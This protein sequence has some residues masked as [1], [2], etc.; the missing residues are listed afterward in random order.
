[1]IRLLDVRPLRASA[2]FR[3]LWLG[4]SSALFGSQVGIVAAPFQI[5]QATGSALWVGAHGLVAGVAMVVFGLVGGTLADAVD[6]KRL[7]LVSSSLSAAAAGLLVLQA[8]LGP[9]PPGVVLLLVGVQTAAIA[10]G[11]AAR[12]TFVSRVLPRDLVTAGVALSHLGFQVALLGGPAVGGL[13]LASGGLAWAY[14]LDAVCTLVS[15]Y[16]VARLPASDPAAPAARAGLRALVDGCRFVVGRPVLGG[17]MTTDAAAVVLSMPVALFPLVNA[18]R[19]GDDPRT[20]GLLYSAVGVGGMAAGL[21]SGSVARAVRPGRVMIAAAAVWGL[22][23]AAFGVVGGFAATLACLAVAGAADT[24]SVIARGGLVQLATPGEYL[25]RVT[26]LETVVGAGGPGIG[27]ARAGLVAALV[28]P[29]LAAVS[30][31]LACAVV[32]GVQAVL[33]PSLR[34][35]R[36][37]DPA[38]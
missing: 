32:V 34:R 11:M 12:R 21:A 17:A 2:A 31:G 19:F 8:A 24:V 28:G 14:A 5:W 38:V 33:N 13:V 3:R 18:E 7:V 1:M 30:G 35:W 6:R 16:G 15:L 26:A 29:S 27:N 22:A 23:L 20:L 25:G 4:S 10:I 36:T 9:G 37:T